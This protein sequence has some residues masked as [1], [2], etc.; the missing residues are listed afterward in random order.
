MNEGRRLKIKNENDLNR[1]S[2]DA[3]FKNARDV[4]EIYLRLINYNMDFKKDIRQLNNRCKYCFYMKD[5]KE[6]IAIYRP[7]ECCYCESKLI[8]SYL[9]KQTLCEKCAA[10]FSLCKECMQNMD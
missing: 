10:D 4:E 7:K 9:S 8:V 2:V 1:V 3:Q 5:N 6:T